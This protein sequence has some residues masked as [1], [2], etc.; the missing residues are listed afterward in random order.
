MARFL[1]QRA[2]VVLIAAFCVIMLLIGAAIWRQFRR[3]DD[4]RGWVRHTWSVLVGVAEFDDAWDSTEA[5]ERGY[6]LNGEERF[7]VPYRAGVERTRERFADLRRLITDNPAQQARL[8][9]L[10]PMLNR[11]LADLAATIELR[12]TAGFEAA[13]ARFQAGPTYTRDSDALLDAMRAEERDLLAGRLAATDRAQAEMRLAALIGAAVAVA[14][15]ALGTYLLVRNAGRRLAMLRL[16][17]ILSARLR[18][19]LDSLSQGVGVFGPKRQLVDWNPC[20]GELLRLPA[21]LLRPGTPYAALVEQTTERGTRLLDTEQEVADAAGAADPVIHE[22]IRPSDQHALELRR[23]LLPD[24]GFVLTVTDMTARVRAEAMLREA[25]TM[26]AV[27]H[28]TGGIAHDFNNLLTVVMGNLEYLRNRLAPNDPMQ[29]RIDRAAWAT[30]RGARLTSH[31]LSFA[32]KQPL[33]PRPLDLRRLVEELMPLLQRTFSK[34][35]DIRLAA[36]AG[37]WPAL[38]DAPQL[39]NALVNIALNARDAMQDEGSLS[40][41]LAN[42]VLDGAYAA[43]HAGVASGEYVMVATSDT[44]GG[45][46]PEAVARAFEPFFTTKPLGEGA[47][48]GLAMVFGFATQSGGHVTIDSAPGKGTT[49]RL[50]LPRAVGL[51]A[52]PAAADA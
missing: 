14:L 41:E 25:Q 50:F 30:R 17:E 46:A 49:V 29:A 2:G 33:A 11:M 5:A 28:L 32:R 12:R 18:T 43:D 31:L 3:L 45:M 47:G 19:S 13:Q 40:I 39:E 4:E 35:I 38:A 8:D 21:Q 44:G 20:L 10:E 52:V 37:L 23:T 6:L 22:R 42:T 48:L 34:Q 1:L 26:Q 36:S 27:S 9:R 7:L 24:G 51:D 15:L 16:Q